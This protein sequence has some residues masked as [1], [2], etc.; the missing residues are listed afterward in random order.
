MISLART[1][2]SP[3]QL[4]RIAGALYLLL[5]I[6]T[7]LHALRVGGGMEERERARARGAVPE[8][9]ARARGGAR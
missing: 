3:K 6:L 1:G 2:V 7:G 9:P 8:T 4:G 5:G